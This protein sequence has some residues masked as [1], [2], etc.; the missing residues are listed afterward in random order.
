MDTLSSATGSL[1][2]LFQLLRHPMHAPVQVQAA[3]KFVQETGRPAGIGSMEDAVSI[4]RKQ[5][6]TFISQE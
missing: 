3:C 2:C 6:G 1:Y 5:K 4:V